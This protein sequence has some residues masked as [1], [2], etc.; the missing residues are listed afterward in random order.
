VLDTD[1]ETTRDGQLI[2]TP[3]YAAP[4]QLRQGQGAIGPAADVY[5]LG[6]V[7]HTM[8][9][10]RPPLQSDDLWKTVEMVLETE[11]ISPRR[12]QPGVPIDLDTITLR[13]LMKEPDRRYRDAGELAADL[14][15]FL[16]DEPIEARPIGR[17]ERTWRWARRNPAVALTSSALAILSVATT[18]AAVVAAVHFRGLERERNT[19]RLAAEK[20]LLDSRL[21]LADSLRVVGLQ[22]QQEKHH[23][24]AAVC[25]AEAANQLPAGDPH[26]IEDELRTSAALRY[27]PRPLARLG[28]P[29]DQPI[30]D[31]VYHPTGDWLIAYPRDR[32]L[33]PTLW[34]IA[35]AEAMPFPADIGK[36]T[37]LSWDRSGQRLLIGTDQARVVIASFPGIETLD[38][39]R[40]ES[41]ITIVALSPD[42]SLLAAAT[43]TRV[44]G[45]RLAP[46]LS[47]DDTVNNKAAPR[48]PAG[49]ESESPLNKVSHSMNR[50]N[51]EWRWD[52]PVP[53]TDLIFS[54]DARHIVAVLADHR[55]TVHRVEGAFSSIPM[56]TA[57]CGRGTIGPTRIGPQFDHRGRLIVWSEGELNWYD[58]DRGISVRTETTPPALFCETRTETGEIVVGCENHL[59]RCDDLTRHD[60]G[61]ETRAS[62]CWLKQ[63]GVM[64]GSAE[65]DSLIRWSADFREGSGWPLFQPDGVI[66]MRIS[67][68][69]RLLTTI[70]ASHQLRVW[71]LPEQPFKPIEIKVDGE[72]SR[73][74]FDQSGEFLLVR[75]ENSAAESDPAVS[76]YRTC[77]G[78][79]VGAQLNPDGRLVD[80]A[81]LGT[82][83]DVVTLAESL[84]GC[85]IDRW[86]GLS[87]KRDQPT[88]RLPI[89]PM[90]RNPND[91]PKDMLA[92]APGGKKIAFIS[93]SPDHATIC[94]FGDNASATK[95]FGP[96]ASWLVNIPQA[97][98]WL[99]ILSDDARATS[100][101]AVINWDN[102]EIVARHTLTNVDAVRVAPRG[103]IAAI[104]S[105]DGKLRLLDTLDGELLDF[106]L[107]ES[108]RATPASFTYDSQR[109][110]TTGRDDHFRL[111]D[112]KG[113]GLAM[114]PIRFPKEA[115]ASLVAGDRAIFVLWHEGMCQ[116]LDTSHGQPL[117][118]GT[119]LPLS[120]ES[121]TIK[122]LGIELSPDAQRLA[123][124]GL[125]SIYMFELGRL[126][127]K[128]EVKGEELRKLCELVSA[129]RM[130][131]GRPI[132]LTVDAWDRLWPRGSWHRVKS[133]RD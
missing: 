131:E 117:Y 22:M 76:I 127:P 122:Q 121:Q 116:L 54:P 84:T 114:R 109:L 39:M 45:W 55:M 62:A 19:Q 67:P 101:I 31:I 8:L 50:W 96:G 69:G 48:R 30:D 16:A 47:A 44:H 72:E 98:R 51:R 10:G 94:N 129:H 118:P 26:L 89:K 91:R 90:R 34:D 64:T 49:R 99:L 111:W 37:A 25:F 12:L 36:V 86:D 73:G 14:R 126:M 3:T 15:R 46:S 79:A 110:L 1:T 128:S 112:L 29:H 70:S 78:I 80:S 125:R 13:C 58:L 100:E 107:P 53:P 113:R 124:T 18:V 52:C 102:D 74:S 65:M 28:E 57:T 27:C 61:V 60:H 66:R 93:Q 17:L 115:I 23:H 20:A 82:S 6:A 32:A 92:V 130:E 5:S 103:D 35:R 132:P 42:G 33:P 88:L 9:T 108:N 81:W 83:L 105:Q 71:E 59:I 41:P 133:G 106:L 87:G 43:S 97:D 63:G 120:R 2:G 21:A 75:P 24:L 104:A 56:L 4:E 85:E 77:D 123:I 95:S 7:L 68:D 40:S 38:Q 11:P 119:L